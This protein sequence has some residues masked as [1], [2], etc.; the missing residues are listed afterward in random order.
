MPQ[1]LGKTRFSDIKGEIKVFTYF[2]N[3]L[4]LNTIKVDPRV[5]VTKWFEVNNQKTSVLHPGDFVKVHLKVN[6]NLDKKDLVHL[7]DYMPSGL[8]ST[9]RRRNFFEDGGNNNETVIYPYLET[10]GKLDFTVGCPIVFDETSNEETTASETIVSLDKASDSNQDKQKCI[11]DEEYY[12]SARVINKGEFVVEPTVIQ[13]FENPSIINVSGGREKIKIEGEMQV[14]S[15]T[16]KNP[17][18]IPVINT[19]EEQLFIQ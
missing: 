1:E 10:R 3:P 11:V 19:T 18:N 8:L 14:E 6:V 7:T 15:D 17:E 13:S 4:D 12:Y 2:E 9:T 5:K 16:A